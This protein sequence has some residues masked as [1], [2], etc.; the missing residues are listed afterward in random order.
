MKNNSKYLLIL[1]IFGFLLLSNLLSYS[2]EYEKNNKKFL[3]N[4]RININGGLNLFYGDIQQYDF[5]P[6][7]DDYRIAYGFSLHKQVSPVFSFGGAL[8]NGKLHGTKINEITQTG[9]NFDAKVFEYNLNTIVNFSNLFGG[10]DQY[11]KFYIYGLAGIGF[12][13][14]ESEVKD[15]VT[16]EVLRKSGFVGSGP[17]KRTTEIVVPVGLGFKFNLS[18][19]I[20]L[21]LQ[22]TIHGVNSDRLDATVN[23]RKYDYYNYTSVGLSYNFN[24]LNIFNVNSERKQERYQ[25]R[26]EKEARRDMNSYNKKAELE[27]RRNAR[28]EMENE[29]REKREQY[30]KLKNKRRPSYRELTPKAAEY[31]IIPITP[32]SISSKK[33]MQDNNNIIEKSGNKISFQD[34]VLLDEGKFIITGNQPSASNTINADRITITPQTENIQQSQIPETGVIFR[35]QIMA[36]QKR[37][38]TQQ[39]ANSFNINKVIV[40]EYINGYYKY[41][42]GMFYYYNMAVDYKNTLLN[43]G[44]SG[45]FIIAYKNGIRVPLKSVI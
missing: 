28:I 26:I 6:Y 22:H 39:L 27:R 43:K 4:W 17:N 1:S 2:Q 30:N 34:D 37:I 40:E 20:G 19:S 9:V 36:S 8:L 11:R 5:A 45:A 29:K 44:I 15:F 32:Y 25:R 18:N 35:V 21:N 14:W 42:A 7:K 16:G 23:N 12:S 24:S 33:I 38:N 41:T 10:F 13:N 3:S 31:D